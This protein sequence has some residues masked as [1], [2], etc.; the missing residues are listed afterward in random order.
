M[1]SRVAR[2]LL[3]V[4]VA[5]FRY[6]AP[7]SP[8]PAPLLQ[9]PAQGATNVDPDTTLRWR[10]VDDLISNGSFESGMSPS[11]YTNGAPDMWQ[12]FTSSTNAWGMGYRIAGTPTP[13]WS[14]PAIGQ[15][16]QDIYIPA[17]AVSA[18]LQ[19]SERIFSPPPP[20]YWLGRLQVMIYI[21]GGWASTLEYAYGSESVFLTHNWVTRTT[22]LM[23]YAG[24]AISLIV[25]AETLDSRAITAWYV[26][27]DGFSFACEYLSAHSRAFSTAVSPPGAEAFWV[28]ALDRYSAFPAWDVSRWGGFLR[29][30]VG[31]SSIRVVQPVTPI[32]IAASHVR[33]TG[34]LVVERAIELLLLI[35]V[36]PG[37]M[38]S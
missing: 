14:Y 32:I 31:G 26:D 9:L 1:N 12:I 6:W 33:V 3:L 13:Y 18:T 23:A 30:A 5:G 21:G 34:F 35:I 19:W 27:L 36:P 15:L 38:C 16:I 2:L 29:E 25:Q 20:P 4:V 37:R 7:A 10:W 11:W 17:D 22:N 8:A 24:Q 28:V